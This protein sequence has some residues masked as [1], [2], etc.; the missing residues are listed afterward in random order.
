MT[1]HRNIIKSQGAQFERFV[2]FMTGW[3]PR[4]PERFRRELARRIWNDPRVLHDG[5]FVRLEGFVSAALRDVDGRLLHVAHGHNIG[6]QEGADYLLTAGLADGTKI[7]AWY[8]APYSGSITPAKTTTAATF[9]SVATEIAAYDESTRRQ[10]VIASVTNEA[11]TGTE[12]NITANAG[13]TIKG[14]GLISN[15]TKQGTSGTLWGHAN[16]D[17][18]IAVTDNQTVGLKYDGSLTLS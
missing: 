11:F 14:L 7:T 9:H 5:D 18:D 1:D 16:Y 10:N 8:M 3:M 13:F 15:S 6:A 2:R 4:I 17:S 12:I